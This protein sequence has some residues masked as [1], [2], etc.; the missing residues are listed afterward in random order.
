MAAF[1]VEGACNRVVVETWL[2]TCLLPVLPSGQVVVMDNTTF[3]KGGCRLAVNSGRWLRA[4]LLYHLTHQSSTRLRDAGPGSRVAFE[5]NWI[6]LIVSEMQWST[7]YAW[8]P[9]C[10]SYC[11]I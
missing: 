11:Y 1:T 3:H 8:R 10:P 2:E 7:S 4:A 6:S 5:K 9:N